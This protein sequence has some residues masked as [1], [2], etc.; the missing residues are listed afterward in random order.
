VEANKKID[1]GI[2]YDIEYRVKFGDQNKWIAEKSSPIF[3]ENNKLIRNS[4]ICRDITEL[5]TNQELL[6]KKN[7][8]ITDSI[9]Y[10]KTIQDAILDSRNKIAERLEDFFILSKPKEIVSGDFYFYKETKNGLIMAVADCTGHGVP[11]GFM[12]MLGNAFLNEIVNTKKVLTP[13]AILDQLRELVMK[14]LHQNNQSSANKDGMDIALVYF[15]N[16]NRYIQYAGAFNPIYIIRKGKLIELEADLFPIGIHINNE[17]TPFTNHTIELEKD[18]S[19]YI[20]SDGYSDQIGG[21]EQ[22]RFGKKH[23]IELLISIQSKTMIEQEQILTESF[24][25]WK[26]SSEQTDDVLVIGIKI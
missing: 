18:D 15:E 7:N 3:D 23:M 2:A 22:K 13:A 11:A 14:S 8:D 24:D 25:V 9:L 21:K 10:A 26:G 20:L 19:L 4:G 6:A 5:K 12:S 1:S 17:V 16:N